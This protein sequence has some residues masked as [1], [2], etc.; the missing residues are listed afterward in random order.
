MPIRT[1]KEFLAGL[2]DDRQIFMEG[3]RI[4]DVTRDK[5]FAGAARSLAELFDMQHDPALHTP[6]ISRPS[7][8]LVTASS[9]RS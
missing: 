6:D 3:E 8:V 2:H 9:T 1:G 5:R 7:T 4:K